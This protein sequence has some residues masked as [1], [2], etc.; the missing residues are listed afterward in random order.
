MTTVSTETIGLSNPWQNSPALVAV[1]VASREWDK[2][3]IAVCVCERNQQGS[4]RM[5][6]PWR[7]EFQ[8]RI[9]LSVSFGYYIN[10][11]KYIAEA[12]AALN[13]ESNLL[14][15]PGERWE[16][17][18]PNCS[19]IIISYED[20]EERAIIEASFLFEEIAMKVA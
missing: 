7:K 11:L 18:G 8:S 10:G 19:K 14:T 6:L 16:R 9:E 2:G 20:T 13:E 17:L 3:R 15:I 5:A 1:I 4:W 12:G